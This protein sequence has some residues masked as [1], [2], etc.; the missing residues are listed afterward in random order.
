MNQ[1]AEDS[2]AC[3]YVDEK[4]R[5]ELHFEYLNRALQ[6]GHLLLQLPG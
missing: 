4:F 5:I 1:A 2:A 6:L 3:L